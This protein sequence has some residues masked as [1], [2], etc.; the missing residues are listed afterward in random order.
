MVTSS[1]MMLLRV[2]PSILPIVTTVGAVV[3][4]IW[5]LVNGLQAENDLR[6]GH[7]RVH[8]VPRH[9]AVATLAVHHDGK[10]VGTGHLPAPAGSSA[11]PVS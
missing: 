1:G 8:A 11:V 3:M 9:R 10:I 2:P 4:F 7:Y 6:R 5:R